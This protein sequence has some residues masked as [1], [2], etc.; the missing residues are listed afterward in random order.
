MKIF[1]SE[2]TSEKAP[3]LRWCRS[4]LL[5]VPVLAVQ[6]AITQL[7]SDSGTPVLGAALAQDDSKPAE[8]ETRRTPALRN[9][10][11]EQLSEAQTFIEAKQYNE[12]LEILFKME[13]AG[14]KREL[15]SYELANLYNLFAF[16]YYSQENYPKALEA[17]RNV[18][19]QPDIPLAMEINTRYTIAQLYFVMEDWQRGIDALNDWFKVADSP[20]AQ[21]YV[22]LGQGYYQLKDYDK[23]LDNTLIAVNMYKDKGKVPK[24]QWYSLLRFLYFEK[25]EIDKTIETLE[26]MI[27][28]YP[29]KQ[30]WVQLSHMYG[31]ARDDS[32]QLAAMDTA[33]VQDFL[34]KDREQV[35][36]AYL[37]LNAEVPYKAARVLDSG[38]KDDT[39]EASSKTLEILGNA[40]RQAQELEKSIPVMEQAAA[41]SDDGEL[42]CRLGSVYLDKEEFRKA[43]E[44]NKKGLARGGVKRPDQ[45]YLVKG[46]AH[47]N[48]SQYDSARSAFKEAA[49]DKRS[50]EY[51]DQWMKYMDNEIARQQELEK[52]ID[53]ASLDLSGE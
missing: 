8:R 27:V 30:Y 19:K 31:E 36:M 41:K 33:Y 48:L 4:A 13:S 18:V 44:A 14:G 1:G 10:V 49:K 12:A 28:Y 16:V 2:F 20:S 15:N 45:C 23:A 22:L 3:V 7:A 35:T 40:W 32:K 46:M 47:F 42:F 5:A 53:V 39:V 6:V 50:K 51:A 11:Y 21:A 34:T 17:Y 38:I 9:K 25:N 37:Y 52:D 43:V 26:E 29:K 24:E